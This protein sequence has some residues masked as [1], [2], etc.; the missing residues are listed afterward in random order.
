MASDN[1]PSSSGSKASHSKLEWDLL[2]ITTNNLRIVSSGI[3][4]PSGWLLVWESITRSP[5]PS[6]WAFDETR[7][8]VKYLN[9]RSLSI[10]RFSRQNR[11]R[12]T[13]P[14]ESPL[15]SW[16]TPTITGLCAK[17][18][19]HGLATQQPPKEPF[20]LIEA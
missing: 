10:S 20:D 16:D 4:P 17:P 13:Q 2:P 8:K 1:V 5:T 15:K 12:G 6:R 19:I 7:A 14:Q 3:K 18:V 11:D 9:P